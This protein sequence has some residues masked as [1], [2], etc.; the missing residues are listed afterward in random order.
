MKRSLI[1]ICNTISICAI[2]IYLIRHHN[3]S[4]QDPW[5]N[6]PAQ[7]EPVNVSHSPTEAVVSSGELVWSP[8]QQ[9]LDNEINS[10]QRRYKPRVF[11]SFD[12]AEFCQHARVLQDW[13]NMFYESF[14]GGEGVQSADRKVIIDAINR[15]GKVLYPWVSHENGILKSISQIASNA[16]ISRGLVLT[17]GTGQMRMA[18]HLIAT[19]RHYHQ[20][21]LPIEVYY[22]GTDD[23]PPTRRAFVESIGPDIRCIDLKGVFGDP[24]EQLG[25]PGGWAIR[26][27]AM[28][29]SHFKEVMLADAD[30]V[31]LRNPEAFF[32]DPGY[33]KTGTLFWKDRAM[34][35]A[36]REKY[37]W[38]DSLLDR[39]GA[40]Y[41]AEMRVGSAWFA[42][43]TAYE[44]ESGVLIIDKV[45]NL[46][47]MLLICHMNLQRE[48]EGMTYELFHGDKESYW[49]GFAL[50]SRRYCWVDGYGGGI[51]LVQG[52]RM[53][54]SPA[55]KKLARTGRAQ[56]EEVTIPSTDP[57]HANVDEFICSLNI[58][59]TW[60]ADGYT[61][62]WFNNG[63][64]VDKGV[65]DRT[66]LD[67]TGW[68]GVNG[69]WFGEGREPYLSLTQVEGAM[70]CIKPAPNDAIHYNDWGVVEKVQS[71]VKI[72]KEYDRKAE[73]AGL[74][75]LNDQTLSCGFEDDNVD[76]VDD[77]H[78]EPITDEG[79][80][81]PEEDEGNIPG[82]EED[83]QGRM[84]GENGREE[85]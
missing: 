35:P 9:I 80:S 52:P 10:A 51:G 71:M 41:R 79:F 53:W 32:N 73:D 23:L 43:E 77:N 14:Q 21:K 68:V 31:L 44:L 45:R 56:G 37:D 16:Y 62:A 6:S 55:L 18:T 59:H 50:T 22:Y 7:P 27:F 61:P 46:G 38:L 15:L 33:K 36:P 12:F 63:L 4:K 85:Q 24:H 70:W 28:L 42:R 2:C 39:L 67:I 78:D 66:Y 17:A 3:D 57:D 65:H 74:I 5:S 75:R 58:L 11:S 34:D 26:P 1:Q 84:Y 20:F 82:A 49:L 64:L 69:R 60:A 72:A 25:L 19:L 13:W 76:N 8:L 54:K 40:E 30:A 83:D 29:A 47:S 81:N 48:R